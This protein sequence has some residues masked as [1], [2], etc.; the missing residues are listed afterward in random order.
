MGKVAIICFH[1]NDCAIH[2][3]YERLAGLPIAP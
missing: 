3:G 1:K 2:R